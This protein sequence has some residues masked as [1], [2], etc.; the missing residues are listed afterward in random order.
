MHLNIDVYRQLIKSEIAAIKENRTFIPVKLPVDK[1]FNDQI[2]HVYSDYRF[3]PFIVS[4]PYIV[5]HHLKRDRTSVI[6]E[7][8]RA[9]S[10]R[11]NQLKTSN[12][13]LKDQ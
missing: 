10:L 1:M 12:N 7:R 9:K 13:T 4:K 3:T 11:R 5:H 8:E 2:K 6:H